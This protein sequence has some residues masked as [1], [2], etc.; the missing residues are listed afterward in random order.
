MEGP[1]LGMI[2]PA[3]NLGTDLHSFLLNGTKIFFKNFQ[4]AAKID[5]R[6]KTNP[7][8]VIHDFSIHTYLSQT[9]GS[10]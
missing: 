7:S 8:K 5:D 2:S 1:V 9:A 6:N 3:H 10:S 4:K